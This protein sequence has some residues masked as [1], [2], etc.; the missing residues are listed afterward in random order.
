AIAAM[1]IWQGYLVAHQTVQREL[2]ATLEGVDRS[3]QL[4]YSAARQR[5]DELIPVLERELGGRPQLDGSADDSGV[6]LMI[7]ADT[8][9]NGDLAHLMRMNENTGADGSVIAKA[10]TGWVRVATMD[11]NAQGDVQFNTV[12]PSNDLLATMLDAGKPAGALMEQQ[13]RWHAMSVLPLVDDEGEVYG[14]LSVTLDVHEQV[15]D[16]LRLVEQ[17]RVAEHGYLA[18]LAR[19]GSAD[20]QWVA[21]GEGGDMGQGV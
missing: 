6:P 17:T 5:A 9:I 21:A 14:G 8:I 10:P 3:M 4:A 16:V 2:A 15:A 18:L 1:I 12:V 7:V 19:T 20:L 13:G 11:R